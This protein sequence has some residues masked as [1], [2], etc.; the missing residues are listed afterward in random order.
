MLRNRTVTC[1]KKITYVTSFDNL[2]DLL[3]K[4]L[5]FLFYL[6]NR[7]QMNYYGIKVH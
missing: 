3:K 4:L 5:T 7:I 2:S 6:L 1:F